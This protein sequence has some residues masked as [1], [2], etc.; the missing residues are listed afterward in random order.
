M[1]AERWRTLFGAHAAAWAR[2]CGSR[3]PKN[4]SVPVTMDVGGLEHVA[5]PP[6]RKPG[7][8]SQWLSYGGG[9][10]TGQERLRRPPSRPRAITTRQAARQAKTV[11]NP[12][13]QPQPH[14]HMIVKQTSQRWT[15]AGEGTFRCFGRQK[16][17]N[18]R[19]AF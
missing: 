11:Y 19:R 18:D 1:Y 14:A 12:A 4:P 10:P 8:S 7:A 16:T 2:K 9:T 3:S 5:A 13:G 6:P 17:K 15:G